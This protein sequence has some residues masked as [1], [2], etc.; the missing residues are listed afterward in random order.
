[1]QYAISL[2][3]QHSAS[4]ISV[5]IEILLSYNADPKIQNF[6]GED[7]YEYADRY[8]FDLEQIIL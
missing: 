4:Q 5:L 6:V 3:G 7:S 8:L 2:T 1:M